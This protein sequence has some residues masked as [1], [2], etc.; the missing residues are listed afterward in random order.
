MLQ[1]TWLNRTLDLLEE[2]EV[3]V[4]LSGAGISVP[5]GVRPFRGK[6]GLWEKE[7]P[8]LVASLSNFRCNPDSFWDFHLAQWANPERFEPNRA[9]HVLSDWEKAGKV[10]GVITQNI[11]GL[12]E[13]AGSTTAPVHGNVN[14]ASCI[15]CS[16]SFEW[17]QLPERLRGE[18]LQCPV[19]EGPVKPGVVLFEEI[20]PEDTWVCAMGL[21]EASSLMIV[22]GSSLEVEPVATLPQSFKQVTDNRLIVISTEPGGKDSL[23]DV[24]IHESADKVFDLL[25]ERVSF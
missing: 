11:D 15:D 23:A 7:D 25:A 9:H 12:H 3:T 19:C 24:V 16:G 8:T 10:A 4:A 21:L 17:G 22:I 20:L 2:A 1:P 13:R 5:S 6:D 14:V 18:H